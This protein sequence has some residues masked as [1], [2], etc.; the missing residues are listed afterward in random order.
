MKLS[1]AGFNALFLREVAPKGDPRRLMAYR[2]SVGVW[3]IGVG[4]TAAAG[5]PRPKLGMRLTEAS[6]IALFKV[7]LVQYELA[8]N[9]AVKGAMTQNEYDAC[10]SLCYNIGVHGFTGST[11]VHMLNQG[12]VADA[13]NAFLMWEHPAELKDRREAE[14]KQFLEG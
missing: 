5:L 6:M 9:T 10:V 14:R 11:V 4:H 7:D 1:D 13:A 8:V 2:D 12:R 3:T